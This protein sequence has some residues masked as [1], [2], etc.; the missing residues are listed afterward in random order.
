MT[1]TAATQ[2]V[3]AIFAAVEQAYGWVPNLI[4]E[5]S[6]SVPTA[7]AYLSGQQALAKGSLS[8]KEQQTVQLTVASV[9]NCH[10]CQ[11]AHAWIGGKAR[12][13]TEGIAAIRSGRLPEDETLANIV[14]ITRLIMEKRGWLSEE[15]LRKAEANGISKTRLYEII[16]YI[17]LKTISNYINHIAHTPVDEQ[18]SA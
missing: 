18:F 11:E 14:E 1:A 3:D 9:N 4:K 7:Q 5:M 10:Y 13:S 16:T 17:G 2:Q 6:R 15:D 8:P 12:I